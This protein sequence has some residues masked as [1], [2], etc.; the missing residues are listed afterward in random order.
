MILS[1]G[2][3]TPDVERAIFIAE[4]ATVTGSVRLEEL[5]SLWFSVVVRGDM[6][7]IAVS[8]GTNVQDGAV[9]HVDSGF[10][11]TIGSY[12]TVGHGAILHGCSI[13]DEVLVG[14]GAVI[15]NGAEIDRESIV[16]AGALVPPGKRFEPRSLLLGTPARVVRSVT[17]EEVI[18]IR[19]NAERYIENA[20]TYASLR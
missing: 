18:E 19:A 13:A 17:D 15:L 6:G 9:L 14:M 20:R 1:L 3:T 16:G 8:T 7:S 4:N 2:E 5:T 11:L 12:V 10:P